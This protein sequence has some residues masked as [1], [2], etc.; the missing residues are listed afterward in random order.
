[1]SHR[2]FVYLVIL[3]ILWTLSVV[4]LGA[5]TRLADAGLGCPDWPG[6]YGHLIFPNTEAE[7]AKAN[8]AYPETPFELELA[9]PEV[10]HRAFAGVLGLL[11]LLVAVVAVR[12]RRVPL[13]EGRSFGGALAPVMVVLVVIQAL[14]GYWTVSYKLLPQVVMVHLGL[15]HTFFLLWVWLLVR[16]DRVQ[17]GGARQERKDRRASPRH[18]CL[19]DTAGRLVVGKLCGAGVS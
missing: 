13:T 5:W 12:Q 16:F 6:C 17:S 10:T 15:G 11:T 8:Q 1:M 9:I 4:A 7:I 3:G 2:V 19:P 14:F 18:C